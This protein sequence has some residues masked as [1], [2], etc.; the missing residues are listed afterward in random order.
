MPVHKRNVPRGQE[1]QIDIQA[2]N[3]SLTD[4]IR[5][6]IERRLRF[7]LSRS[8]D[9]IR[10]IVLRLS[11]INGPRGGVDKL[12]HLQVVLHALPDVVVKDIQA[13]LYLAI[14]RA[15]DRAGRT[16]ERKIERQKR[17]LKKDSSLES[18]PVIVD[19]VSPPDWET[20]E[21]FVDRD[22]DEIN[23]HH[24]GSRV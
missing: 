23:S 13:D 21:S 3:F 18:V 24:K 22:N 11:D 14:D 15:T 20:N 1:V 17:L 12:C 7:A 10:H 5:S 19:L 4:A 8:D 2:R 16:V 6:H 9:H